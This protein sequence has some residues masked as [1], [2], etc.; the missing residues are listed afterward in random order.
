LL[1]LLLLSQLLQLPLLLLLPLPPL[2]HWVAAADVVA[3]AAG[4]RNGARAG[5]ASGARV[6]CHFGDA[7][8]SNEGCGEVDPCECDADNGK[9][10]E[11]ACGDIACDAEN[12]ADSDVA[13][14]RNP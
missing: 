12:D 9:D 3:V 14:T 4:E 1:W 13:R 11:V 10:L 7:A 2:L 8:D 6:P 5:S